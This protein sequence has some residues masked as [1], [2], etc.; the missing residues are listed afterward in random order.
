MSAKQKKQRRQPL[1][2]QQKKAADL[3]FENPQITKLAALVGVDRTT[4]WRWMKRD[5]FRRELDRAIARNEKKWRAEM[6][7]RYRADLAAERKTPE[8]QKKQRRKYE[9]R[10]RLKQVEQRLENAESLKEAQRLQNELERLYN[11]AYFD[12]MTAAEYLGQFERNWWK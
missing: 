8:Y 6:M 9:A 11:I 7:R 3:Y 4:I 12:G 2:E 5:D 1:T 10:R